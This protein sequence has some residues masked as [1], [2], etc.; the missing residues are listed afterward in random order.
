MGTG[1]KKRV[2]A[3]AVAESLGAAALVALG[4]EVWQAVSNHAP[5]VREYDA[6]ALNDRVP[7]A[8]R[9]AMTVVPFF[10][11]PGSRTTLPPAWRMAS[12]FARMSVTPSAMWP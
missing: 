3:L 9:R 7:D 4:R 2:L 1:R 12:H 8:V 11:G 5:R 10:I 6:S